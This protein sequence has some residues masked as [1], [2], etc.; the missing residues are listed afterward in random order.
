[1]AIYF[2]NMALSS[3]RRKIF[4]NAQGFLRKRKKLLDA[5]KTL[6]FTNGCFDIIHRGHVEYLLSA[7]ELGDFLIIGLNTNNS[8]RRLKG[9]KRPINTLEDRAIV[10]AALSFVDAVIPFDEATPLELIKL[11]KPD[12]LVKGADYEIDEIVGAKEVLS[13]GGKVERIQFLEGFSTSDL[14]N[15]IKRL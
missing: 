6:V 13:W 1:M 4:A 15:K 3:P 12:V 9:D 5:H 8:I 7:R 14:L 10:L 11:V 2:Y